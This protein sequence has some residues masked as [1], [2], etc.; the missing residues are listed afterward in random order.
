MVNPIITEFEEIFGLITATE[1]K[2][3]SDR[4]DA[5]QAKAVRI[6]AEAIHKFAPEVAEQI[7]TKWNDADKAFTDLLDLLRLPSGHD[8]GGQSNG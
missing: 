2:W 8:A 3:L 4:I 1:R 5:E 6:L 7:R